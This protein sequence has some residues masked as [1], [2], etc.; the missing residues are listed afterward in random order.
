MGVRDFFRGFFDKD[1]EIKSLK[2]CSHGVDI[3]TKY[4]I[5]ALESSIELISKTVARAEFQTYL[6][7]KPTK[8]GLYYTFNL[9]PNRNKS[10]SIFWKEVIRTLI[11]KGEALVIVQHHK[12]YLAS[13]FERTERAFLDNI[14]TEVKIGD[15]ELNDTWY[16]NQVLYLT[17]DNK[18][19][20][21]A[22]NSIYVD[23]SKLIA[24]SIKGYQNSK[25]RKG[26]LSIP[27]SMPKTLDGVEDLGTHIQESMKDFMDPSKD[28]V[29]PEDEGFEYTELT[30]SKGSKSNDSGRETK[31]FINDVFDMVAIG[32]GIPPSLLKG[33]TVDTKDAVNNFLTFCINPLAKLI[34]D[35]IN[36]KMY[37]KEEYLKNSYVKVDTTNIKAVDLKDIANSIDL[38]N[39]NGALT[40]DDTLRI[41][42]KEPIGGDIGSMRFI[43]KNLELL[44]AVLREGS[45]TD[46][47]GGSDY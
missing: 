4:K 12:L 2:S 27:S 13:S 3:N 44:D 9:E 11:T 45:V 8:G 10:A 32:F 7:G 40:I 21:S 47:K 24:S 43:T 28:A 42:G 34:Q 35:E 22:I 25:A 17:H 16:E 41:L 26:K 30:E 23:L 31:N 29:Y 14:Y 19:I 38:L 46:L 39:R 18:D 20:R 15:Y 5:L 36:R 1:N 6:K 33:D 37:G